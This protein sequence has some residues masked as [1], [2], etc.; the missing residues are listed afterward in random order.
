MVDVEQLALQRSRCPEMS[1]ADFRFMLQQIDGR[2]RT[3]HK[4]PTF[5]AWDDWWYPVRL[6][7]EQCSSETTARY[8]AQVIAAYPC[9][10]NLP[11]NTLSVADLTGGYGVDS[12]F[13]S[14]QFGRVDYVERNEELC[15]IAEHNFALHAPNIRVHNTD[16]ESYLHRMQPV[17]VIY[18]DPA[19]RDKNGGKVFRIEDCEPNLL[20]LLPVLR[21][22]AKVL[23]LKLSPMLDITA[24][25]QALSGLT[26]DT[27]VVAVSNEVKE[28]LL[29]GATFPINEHSTYSDVPT[30]RFPHSEHENMAGQLTVINGEPIS[31]IDGT[32][33]STLSGQPFTV[34]RHAERDAIPTWADC[35]DRYLYEPNA[36]ILKAGLY[37]YV[38]AHWHIDKLAPNTHLYTSSALL[39]NFPGRVWEV[40]TPDTPLRQCNIVIRN[41]PLTPDQLKKKLKVRDGGDLYIIASRLGNKPMHVIAKRVH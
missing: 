12:Y 13:I 11:A 29:I 37:N 31:P 8:K 18:M 1:D 27:H 15:R 38:S 4:L 36:A 25:I 7:C 23:L 41:Y 32:H 24:A 5:A 17:D 21:T 14:R 20:A 35:I 10:A 33:A 9:L 3:A 39:P 22:K 34:P 19:R 40:C 28:V 16:A 30:I 2:Q 6:S 26:W